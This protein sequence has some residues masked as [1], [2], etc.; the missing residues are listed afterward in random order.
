MKLRRRYPSEVDG[1]AG[2]KDV[3][4]WEFKENDRSLIWKGFRQ[5]WT[6]ISSFPPFLCHPLL[7]GGRFSWRTPKYLNWREREL[8]KGELPGASLPHSSALPI[9]KIK[10]IETYRSNLINSCY[11]KRQ[12]FSNCLVSGSPEPFKNA[13]CPSFKT[14]CTFS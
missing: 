3:K 2:D 5:G 4:R 6:L 13:F 11:A 9:Y 1:E 12:M 7:R 14:L 8:N 10:K